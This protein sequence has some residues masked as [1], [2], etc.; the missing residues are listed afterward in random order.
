M[1]N[2]TKFQLFPRGGGSYDFCATYYIH[3]QILCPDLP[4]S[5]VESVHVSVHAY[6]ESSYSVFL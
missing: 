1:Y 4:P 5:F 6:D 2:A 3:V